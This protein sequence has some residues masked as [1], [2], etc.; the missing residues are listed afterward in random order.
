MAAIM[1]SVLAVGVSIS[2]S[3]MVRDP[4]T[5]ITVADDLTIVPYA[6]SIVIKTRTHNGKLQYRRWNETRNCWVDP[7][8]IDA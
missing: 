7:Y 4:E 5:M 1:I 8:W 6:D 2:A 3:A